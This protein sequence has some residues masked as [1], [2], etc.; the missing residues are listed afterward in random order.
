MPDQHSEDHS[1]NFLPDFC[2]RE[3]LLL[4]LLI[5]ALLCILLAL[6][7]GG[8]LDEMLAHFALQALFV[9]WI[10]LIDVALLCHLRNWQGRSHTQLHPGL[11]GALAFALLQLVTLAFTLIT[12]WLADWQ[13]P[14][15]PQDWLAHN[16]LPNLTISAIVTA[17]AL[18]YFYIAHQW[19]QGV[20]AEERAR[21]A[22]LQARIR[23]HFLFNS[24]NSVA[25]L[26][27]VDPQAAEDAVLDLAELFRAS[28]GERQRLSLAEEVALAQ[29]YLRIEAQRLGERLRVVWELPEP[30]PDIQLPALTLQP[31][32]ENGVYHGIEPRSDGGL[33]RIV[34]EQR[35][36]A[37]HIE[38]VN[39]LP[40]DLPQEGGTARRAGNHMALENTRQRLL[41][42]FGE[43]A[44]LETG[45]RGDQ[46]VARLR[47]PLKN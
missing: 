10:A 15:W 13:M 40:A 33:L 22:A 14:G 20:Q 38:I 41:L 23:P 25:S 43:R 3:A 45:A 27:H 37:L 26:T 9:T 12:D 35:G 7:G 47:L 6:A 16:L 28:L 34:A 30:L 5:A 44:A 29:S 18:R 11:L 24:L 8:T 4:V 36:G 19:R 17:I 39:P 2:S 21:F 32:L 31:L 42:A 1:D 46:Y